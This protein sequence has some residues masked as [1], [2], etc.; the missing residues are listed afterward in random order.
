MILQNLAQTAIQSN[1]LFLAIW[2]VFRTVKSFPPNAKAWIWRLAFLKPIAGLLPFAAVTLHILT[3]TPIVA[4]NS[5]TNH[6]AETPAATGSFTSI[7]VTPETPE[8]TTDPMLILWIAGATS[9][10]GWALVSRL[11]AA[12]IVRWAEPVTNQNIVSVLDDLLVK[13]NL[14]TSITLLNSTGVQ[15]AM[16][17]GGR[18]N[19]VVLPASSKDFSEIRMM[20]AHEVAHIARRDL[21]WQTVTWVVR[22]LF[23]FNPIVW[24][25]V[26]SS[27]LDHESATDRYA[28]ELAGV[29]VQTY[30][31][32]LLRATV[33]T[34]NPLVP[35]AL[36]VGESYRTIHRRLEAMNHFNSKP[37]PMRKTAVGLVALATIGLIPM[38]QFA[39]AQSDQSKDVKTKVVSEK[40]SKQNS[41]DARPADIAVATLRGESRRVVDLSPSLRSQGNPADGR[42][43]VD[44][45]QSGPRAQTEAE[46][47][48]QIPN[49]ALVEPRNAVAPSGSLVQGKIVETGNK[50]SARS[51]DRDK[52]MVDGILVDPQA[53]SARPDQAVN[54][55]VRMNGQP[56]VGSEPAT[57]QPSAR[58][59]VA[60]GS[61]RPQSAWDPPVP[62]TDRAV[63][64]A[65]A[66][67]D[68]FLTSGSVARAAEPNPFGGSRP[69]QLEA[70]SPD[71]GRLI[72]F[73]FE[74]AD[75]RQALIKLFEVAGRSFLL[76]SDIKGTIS[77]SGQ[78]VP[79]DMA[80]AEIM[81]A[82]KI[83]SYTENGTIVIF[84]Q[85]G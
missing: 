59:A 77:V 14:K 74:N 24:L 44:L 34:R 49:G 33:V 51:N 10:A 1:I 69:S 6:I 84:A 46:R 38:Y 17:F 41:K 65:P 47:V 11:Q 52:V 61:K 20:L 54:A 45:A 55:K 79:F 2:F 39:Q 7:Q 57:R 37:S 27:Q 5:P 67:S 26:R 30:A 12:K 15:S 31:E 36:S 40:K 19:I 64:V 29:P 48:R 25:A 80:L 83:E 68:P 13:A 35:G 4:V 78:K 81:K 22:S 63:R 72:T 9:V 56:A 85:K 28:C 60:V 62:R 53:R 70:T 18:R 32:M 3:A 8:P 75:V 58:E 50:K 82:A 16:L 71:S 21:A 42:R 23:F 76:G 66:Q 43:V 73:K